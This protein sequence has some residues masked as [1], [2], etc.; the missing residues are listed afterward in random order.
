MDPDPNAFSEEACLMDD[1]QACED[2]VDDH[3]KP[4]L[5]FNSNQFGK[6]Q[7]QVTYNPPPVYYVK[8][9]EFVKF[10]LWNLMAYG[11]I[12]FDCGAL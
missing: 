2:W 8:F 11:M 5:V 3:G 12:D 9:V 7:V 1:W 10:N 4:N 6:S